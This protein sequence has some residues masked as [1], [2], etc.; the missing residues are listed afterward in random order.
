MWSARYVH[1]ASQNKPIVNVEGMESGDSEEQ[2]AGK[3]KH[4]LTKPKIKSLVD[5]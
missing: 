3:P 4:K 1:L 2:A 5:I